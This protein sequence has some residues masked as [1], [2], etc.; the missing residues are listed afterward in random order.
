MM[1]VSLI[2]DRL[3]P[4]KEPPTTTAVSIAAEAPV[5]EATPAAIGVRATMVPTLVPMLN[6][7]KQ[8]ARNSP[9]N[10]ICEGRRAS[11]RL[12]VASIDPM[13]LAELAKAPASTNIHIISIISG[14][15]APRLNTFMRR[16]SFPFV[17]AMA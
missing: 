6:E 14:V 4:K 5:C 3:S 9:G 13:I 15:P 2:N 10:S 11:V 16:R 17:M 7:M 8:A 12:T 1:V